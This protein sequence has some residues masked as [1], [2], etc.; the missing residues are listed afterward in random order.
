MFPPGNADNPHGAERWP[1][2]QRSRVFGPSDDLPGRMAQ[3][4]A[5]V[6]VS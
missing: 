2:V 3:A 1:Q 6:I 5:P 4:G